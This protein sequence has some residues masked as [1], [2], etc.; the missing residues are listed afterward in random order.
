MRPPFSRLL[1]LGRTFATESA[2]SSNSTAPPARLQGFIRASHA[3]FPPLSTLKATPGAVETARL[4]AEHAEWTEQQ[5]L[6][7]RRTLGLDKYD[8][9]EHRD[10][11]RDPFGPG[12]FLPNE[13]RYYGT[14]RRKESVARVWVRP[15]SS[16]TTTPTASSSPS[17][18]V[19]SVSARDSLTLSE[20]FPRIQHRSDALYPL[21]VSGLLEKVQVDV[22]VHGGGL[23]GFLSSPFLSSSN[24][25]FL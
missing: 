19:M 21:V 8:N 17:F 3:L 18:R 4:Y 1:V 24:P 5:R 23:S 16:S 14:G 15:L 25:P 9:P 11:T 7:V 20:Y 12:R 13:G 22:L 10:L 2:S 6:A